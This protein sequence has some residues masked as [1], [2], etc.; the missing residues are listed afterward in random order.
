MSKHMVKKLFGVKKCCVQ[1]KMSPPLLLF[2]M[3]LKFHLKTMDLSLFLEGG[4]VSRKDHLVTLLICHYW[5]GWVGVQ[6][7]SD[8]VSLYH[9]FFWTASLRNVKKFSAPWNTGLVVINAEKSVG[10]IRPPTP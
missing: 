1:K 9:V 6:G 5:L 10:S 7:R 8:N 3:F 4:W 2:F